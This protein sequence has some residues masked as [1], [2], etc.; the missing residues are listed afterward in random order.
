MPFGLLN[1]PSIFQRF[2]NKVFSDMLDICVV[3]YLDD[4][5]IYSDNL[6]SYKN[7][8]REVLN[9][10]QN[11]RLYMSPAKCAFHW[12]KVEFLGFILGLKGIQMD[13][14]K[15]Q[16]IQDWLVPWQVKDIQAFIGFANFYQCFI[17][18]Y[19]ELIIL[20]IR[21]TRKKKPWNWSSQCQSSF[22]TL[23]RAFNSVPVLAHWDSDS[24]IIV[25]TDASDYALAA[26]LSTYKE[27]EIYPIMF[28]SWAFSPTELNYDIH[29][30][31]LLAIFEAFKKWQYYLEGTPISVEI[32]TDHKNL[33]YFC[34]SKSL[35]CQQTR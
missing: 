19:L 8:V 34:E 15:V 7:H 10:L 2:M 28:H 26:I 20:L 27:G 21:L 16:T 12:R 29:D 1:V 3:V 6:E 11:N 5:L 30:K 9:R 23:K 31:E 22:E 17:K 4:I 32:F 14:K 33:I 24:P 35:S 25:G 18:G 13:P